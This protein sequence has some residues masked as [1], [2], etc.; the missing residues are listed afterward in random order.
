M[1]E[2]LLLAADILENNWAFEVRYN[3][4]WHPTSANTIECNLDKKD[5]R[6][7]D[8]AG[9]PRGKGQKPL[10][11]EYLRAAADL[12]GQTFFYRLS[13]ISLWRESE[14]ITRAVHWIWEIK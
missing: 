10:T 1:R 14:D 7:A 5:L 11:P 9:K 8:G 4:I 3:E 2:K 12:V 13:S 6:R